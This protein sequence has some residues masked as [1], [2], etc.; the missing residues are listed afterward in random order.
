MTL[1]ERERVR[2]ESHVGPSGEG[3]SGGVLTQQRQAGEALLQEGDAAVARA[4]RVDER[5]RRA[6]AQ[7]FVGR[8]EA[9]DAGADDD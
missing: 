5:D 3:S 1:H 6:P 9:D 7:R 8:P 2:P 4:S